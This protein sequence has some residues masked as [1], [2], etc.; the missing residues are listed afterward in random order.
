MLKLITRGGRLPTMISI[1]IPTLNEASL[2]RPTLQALRALGS[3]PEVLCA[4]GGST[5]ETVDIAASEGARVVRSNCG[6]GIQLHAGAQHAQGDVLWF[7]HADT[8]VPS[9]ATA[10]IG[11]ALVNERV[12]AGNFRLLFSGGSRGAVFLNALYPKLAWL[13][14]RY[15]D[16]GLWVRQATYE[17]AGGFRPLPLFEDLDFLRRVKAYGRLRTLP[18]PLTTSSRRFEHRAF[19]PVF[20]RWTVLQ[21]L[22]W[23][24][25]DPHRLGQWYYPR[26]RPAAGTLR[27]EAG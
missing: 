21:L 4:D 5:D 12:V 2:L 1:I 17:R 11:S 26:S 24:G 15:G 13:G 6:R 18:G 23:L 10:Q 20:A 22:Y 19:T 9:D 8:L 7:L 25:G 27:K 14:L 3:G 16:S